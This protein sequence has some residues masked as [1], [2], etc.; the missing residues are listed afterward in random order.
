MKTPIKTALVF[1]A[2]AGLAGTSAVASERHG[3][4]GD[5]KHGQSMMERFDKVDADASGDVTFEEFSKAA[6][7]RFANA[8]ADGDGKMTVAEIAAEIQ[9]QRAERRARR[10]VERFDSDGD[11]LLTQDEIESRQ[12]KMFALM[13]RN[14]DGKV[15]REELPRHEYG[16]HGKKHRRY[17]HRR[18]DE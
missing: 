17:M 3:N 15:M 11:G 13:D 14:D 1:I 10:I 9:R 4:R 2:I 7:S 18:N 6:S 12:R 16:R 8:D 5:R